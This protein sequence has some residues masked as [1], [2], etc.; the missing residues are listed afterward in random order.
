MELVQKFE[1]SV[2]ENFKKVRRIINENWEFVG[3]RNMKNVL[4]ELKKFG[5]KVGKFFS[6]CRKIMRILWEKI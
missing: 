3:P 6:K 5:E 2:T 4:E 1:R